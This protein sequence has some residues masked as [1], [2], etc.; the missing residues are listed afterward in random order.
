MQLAAQ[1][2]AVRSSPPQA[3]RMLQQSLVTAQK[4]EK[5][6]HWSTKRALGQGASGF[7]SLLQNKATGEQVVCKLCN[8]EDTNTVQMEV[9]ILA[10]LEH[11]HVVRYHGVW[12][13]REQSRM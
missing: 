2:R 9:N 10:S 13:G 11:P 7:V 4:S 6:L 3:E 12:L 5:Y 1:A 8:V